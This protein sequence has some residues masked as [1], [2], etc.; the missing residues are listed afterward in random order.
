MA[1]GRRKDEV[2]PELIRLLDAGDLYSRYGA[3]QALRLQRGRGD[4]AVA[5]LRKTTRADDLWLRVLA[6]EALGGIGKPARAASGELLAKLTRSDPKNDPR[7][8]EQ[9]YLTFVLFGG[10][11]GLLGRSLEGID[12]ELL[13]KA[14]RA[15]LQNEDGRARGN[16]RSVYQN[17]TYDEIKPLLGAINQAIIVPAPSGIMFAD[18][19]RI[20]GLELFAKYRISEGMEGIVRYARDQKLHGSKP[21]LEKVMKLLVGYGA[22]AK[23]MIPKLRELAAYFPTQTA[24]PRSIN[25]EKSRIVEATIKKIQASTDYPKLIHLNKAAQQ[26]H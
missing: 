16:I 21:R 6:A 20:S 26:K 17:L 19:I 2:V 11:G 7:N 1:L 9:R 15:A 24:H 14:V 8:M 18:G 12:R 25:L 10:R 13:Y 22:H 5:A 23:S 3:C 4:R